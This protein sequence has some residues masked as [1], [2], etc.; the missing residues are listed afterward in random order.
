MLS[1]KVSAYLRPIR[2]CTHTGDI[3][4]AETVANV[5]TSLPFIA[6]GLQA[7]RKNVNCKIYA[8][9]LV[10]VGLASSLYH[11]S[12]G[13]LRKYLRW[14]DYTMIATLLKCLSRALRNENPKLLMTDSIAFVSTYT[15]ELWRCFFHI[16]SFNSALAL[17][18][19]YMLHNQCG[20][21]FMADDL[22]PQTPFLHA[23]VGVATCNKLLD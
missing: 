14:A 2:C 18:S 8:N 4:I 1:R 22:L 3:N 9:S 5:L 13:R 16:E 6:I 7:P 23:A 12:R 20:A 15:K 10:G 21:F 17:R 19:L 11:A